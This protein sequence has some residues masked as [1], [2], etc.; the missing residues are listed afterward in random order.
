MSDEVKEAHSPGL[1][2]VIAGESAICWVHPDAGLLH[3]GYDIHE[4][5]KKVELPRRH[6]RAGTFM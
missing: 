1:A 6:M 5:A 3:R 2:G 4:L